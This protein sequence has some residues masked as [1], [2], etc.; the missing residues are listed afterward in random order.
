MQST[1]TWRDRAMWTLLHQSDC[2][3][4]SDMIDVLQD[5]N[6]LEISTKLP[7]IIWRCSRSFW[8]RRVLSTG[9]AAKIRLEL[10][11]I[12]SKRERKIW[13]HSNIL[14]EYCG[15]LDKSIV[16]SYQYKAQPHHISIIEK[17]A[18]APTYKRKHSFQFHGVWSPNMRYLLTMTMRIQAE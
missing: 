5:M 7:L 15:N 12:K 14:C 9:T 3:R 1:E 11:Q 6:V 16:I 2:C 10:A 4:K 18:I 8:I 17:L 13:L